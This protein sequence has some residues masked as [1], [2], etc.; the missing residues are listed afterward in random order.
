MLCHLF[1][2]MNMRI[3]LEMRIKCQNACKITPARFAATGGNFVAGVK[4]KSLSVERAAALEEKLLTV[5]YL[6]VPSKTNHLSHYGNSI[7]CASLVLA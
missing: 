1:L 6:V 7:T 4:R 3:Q 2:K 5:C